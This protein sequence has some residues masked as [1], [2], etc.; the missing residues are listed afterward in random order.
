LDGWVGV[1]VRVCHLSRASPTTD[2]PFPSNSFHHHVSHIH[3]HTNTHTHTHPHTYVYTHTHIQMGALR[4]QRAR[5]AG[6]RGGLPTGA[7]AFGVRWWWTLVV[8]VMGTTVVGIQGGMNRLLDRHILN[9]VHLNPSSAIHHPTTTQTHP[10]TYPPTHPPTHNNHSARIRV[11]C[12]PY[13][14]LSTDHNSPTTDAVVWGRTITCY[15]PK[16]VQA[17]GPMPWLTRL[18]VPVGE[19][20]LMYICVYMC[21]VVCDVCLLS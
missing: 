17:P 18:R 8:V 5:G 7:A 6:Q 1:S 15:S 13:R 9:A 11:F 3:T 2:G 12:T 10:R 14:Q 21:V 16:A 4:P 19:V 20:R